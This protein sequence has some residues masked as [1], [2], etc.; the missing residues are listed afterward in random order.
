MQ[1]LLPVSSAETNT[2]GNWAEYIRHVSFNLKEAVK[3]FKSKNK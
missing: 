2:D 3:T 1:N